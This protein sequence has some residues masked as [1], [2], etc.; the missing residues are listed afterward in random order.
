MNERFYY[1]PEMF[2]SPD[3]LVVCYGVP[4]PTP[5]FVYNALGK[6]ALPTKEQVIRDTVDSIAARFD[7]RYGEQKWLS[8]IAQLVADDPLALQ[9]F[10]DGDMTLFDTNQFHQLGGLHALAR[11]TQRDD[12][13]EAL[14]Q[15][16][17]IRQT[18]EIANKN[19]TS[20][21]S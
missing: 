10:L 3:K 12:V 14:R 21:K 1:K 2:Y 7:L 13:F 5:S 11:F 6:K 16:A 18:L 4:A 17:L 8:A 19:L 15:S 20:R 9:K